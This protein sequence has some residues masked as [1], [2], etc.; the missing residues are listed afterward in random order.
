MCLSDWSPTTELFGTKSSSHPV[1]FTNEGIPTSARVPAISQCSA[2]S[3]KGIQ[4][5][6]AI[7]LD[8]GRYRFGK[9][10]MTYRR[11][12]LAAWRRG[13]RWLSIV[14]VDGVTVEVI[15]LA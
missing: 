5:A 3:H 11:A 13:F 12:Q 1:D 14:T 8:D 7:R 4:M 9:R 6:K 10:T 2:T 15:D